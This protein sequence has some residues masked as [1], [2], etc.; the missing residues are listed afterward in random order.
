MEIN[1]KQVCYNQYYSHIERLYNDIYLKELNI[2]ESPYKEDIY[3]KHSFH[4]ILEYDSRYIG[5]V[6]IIKPVNS[7]PAFEIVKPNVLVDIENSIE[8]SRLMIEKEYRLIPTVLIK[9]LRHML[10]LLLKEN[11]GSIIVDAFYNGNNKTDD[12]FK[13]I[14]FKQ[15][16]DTYNDTRFIDRKC[17]LLYLDLKNKQVENADNINLKR[18]II[19]EYNKLFS[20]H[21]IVAK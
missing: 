9:L 5:Y 15:I 21:N 3:D 12:L 16:S 20:I 7:L 18:Y 1:I 17:I 19:K 13:S 2:I 8:I 10:I 4:L 14:G 6:R 11:I